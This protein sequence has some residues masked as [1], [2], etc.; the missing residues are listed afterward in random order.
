MLDHC[1]QYDAP[2]RDVATISRLYIRKKC[3][4]TRGT[5]AIGTDQQV[6]P[7]S[8]PVGEANFDIGAVLFD[9]LDRATVVVTLLRKGL[10]KPSK[11]Q[12][13]GSHEL[14]G[15]TAR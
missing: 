5:C 7:F 2:P 6:A 8:S 14:C 13:P 3:L 4:P 12:S 11:Q 15:A 10:A 9:T 1:L